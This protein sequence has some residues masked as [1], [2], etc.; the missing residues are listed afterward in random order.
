MTPKK[1]QH[2]QLLITMR[3]LQLHREGFERISYDDLERVFFEFKTKHKQPISLHEWANVILNISTDDIIRYLSLA[4]TVSS[5]KSTIGDVLM[6][7][8]I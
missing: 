3:L 1:Q 4:A 5:R 2:I 7:G 8:D 6:E